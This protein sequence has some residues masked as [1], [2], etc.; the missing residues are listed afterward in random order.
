MSD[1]DPELIMT[2]LNSSDLISRTAAFLF[3]ASTDNKAGVK[4]DDLDEWQKVSVLNMAEHLLVYIGVL[5]ED[6]EYI[7]KLEDHG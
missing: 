7:T 1:E 4:I 3:R 6:W 5:P 2:H